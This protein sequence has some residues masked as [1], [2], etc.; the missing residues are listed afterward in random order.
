MVRESTVSDLPAPSTARVTAATRRF[1]LLTLVCLSLICVA[2]LALGVPRQ[3]F[4]GHD[5]FVPLD[6][7]WRILNGQRP[8]TDFYAQLGPLFHLLNAAGLALAGGD[9]RGLGYASALA[10][11]LFA[12]W[13]FLLLRRSMVPAV[14]PL[15][16][17]ATT[18]LAVAPFALGWEPWWTT[19]AMSY[20]RYGFALAILVLLESFLPASGR[21]SSGTAGA[22]STGLACGLA[23]FL[24]ISY[25]FG[26]L[27]IAAVAL[28][29]LPQRL[30][31][32]AVFAAGFAC[33]VLPVLIWLR[34]DFP[35][36][37]REHTLLAA[38]RGG[39]L[40]AVGFFKGL[41]QNR[42]EMAPL[43][44]LAVFAIGLPGV[45]RPRRLALTTAA[46]LAALLAVLLALTNTQAEGV[47]LLAGA[48][49][50]VLNELALV[51]RSRF[52]PA[53]RPLFAFAILAVAIPAAADAF[54]L[55]YALIDK[56][57]P[58]QPGYR[59]ADPALR[60]IEF[61][62]CPPDGLLVCSTA[63]NG[64]RFISYTTEGI[65]LVRTWSRPSDSVL[66][67]G[68]SNPFSFALHRPPAHGG[69]VDLSSANISQLAMPPKSM[70]VGDVELIL[71]PTFTA[72]ERGSLQLIVDHYPE[73][74]G[75]DY[76]AIASSPHWK[77]YRRFR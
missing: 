36:L 27:G 45:P 51:N 11:G 52:V 44:L 1:E 77:L 23:L 49:L 28:I 14:F 12:V 50:L 37:I 74:L 70:L 32:T 10:G 61:V 17:L 39:T 60:A 57:L 24:K 72:T 33:V 59:F 66:G 5:I 68:L 21:D 75:S 29:F 48:A 46:L 35:A 64:E 76:T 71:F 42:F 58:S 56:F 8:V 38:A 19:S 34:F 53:L 13:S 20:N 3:H 43:L 7:A 2:L 6:G 67:T 26:C 15:A 9:S 62:D 69:A 65:D 25:G 55:A 31:R 30:R 54:G 4:F 16:C 40:T 73:L 63:D 47:P 18:L 41:Y 22:F